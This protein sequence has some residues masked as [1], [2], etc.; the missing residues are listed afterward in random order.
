MPPPDVPRQRTHSN[1]SAHSAH[2][3]H[4]RASSHHR[5]AS[6][7]MGYDGGEAGRRMAEED[8]LIR[9]ELADTDA[10]CNAFWGTSS[11]G[12]DTV[13]ARMKHA[14][15]T[16][17]AVRALYKERADIEADYAKRLGKLSKA[18][19]DLGLHETG[20]TKIALETVRF[21]VERMSSTHADLG[22]MIKKDLDG[23]MADFIG[24]WAGA[25]RNSSAAI[26]KLW[27]QKQT[28]ESYVNKSRE[29]YEQD[30]IKIN[31]YTAQSSLVQGRDL[32]KVTAKLDKAQATVS[33]NEKDYQ[34][35]V[36]AL[37]DTTHK[38]NAE[39]KSY[40]DQCQD[41]EEERLDFIKA[42]LWNYANAVSAVCVA[43]DESCENVRV[44]LEN[45]EASRDIQAFIQAQGTGSAIPDPPEYINYARGQPP[46]ARPSYK[47]ANFQRNS[48]RPPPQ[49]PPPGPP[50]SQ[51]PPPPAV[52]VPPI[53]PQ[54]HGHAPSDA[55]TRKSSSGGS[56]SGSQAPRPPA[57]RTG[58]GLGDMSDIAAA[59]EQA[60]QEPANGQERGSSK[61]PSGAVALPGL[62]STQT[63]S[64]ASYA[65]PLAPSPA[66]E[67]A[68]HVQSV[69]PER[70]AI[71]E[72][73]MSARNFIART[74]SL[75]KRTANAPEGAVNQGSATPQGVPSRPP[76]GKADPE[77]DPLAKALQNLRNRPGGR[78]PAPP[79]PGPA[80][81]TKSPAPGE[82]FPAH[83][84]PPLRAA[85][86][87]PSPGPG[88]PP[89]A[90]SP[91][92]AF[93][94]A[95]ERA[96]SPAVVEEYG[97]SFPGERR[98]LSRQN[99]NVS[100][101]VPAKPQQH[102][103]Q[104]QRPQAGGYPGGIERA[105]SPGP[106][107]GQGFAGVGARG[108]SPS[109]A[110][111]AQSGVASRPSG[112]Q[113]QGFKAPQHPPVRSTTPL[114][115]SL[116]A[117][118]S[119]TH[120]QMAD[121][122]NRR[123]GS[124]GPGA[125]RPGVH[126]STAPASHYQQPS[127]SQQ[128]PPGQ[129]Y[130]PGPQA[131]QHLPPQQQQRPS[132][133][134]QQHPS[135]LY[136]QS[137]HHQ[138]QPSMASHYSGAQQQG[139]GGT[140]GAYAPQ[141][142]HHQQQMS[143]ASTAPALAAQPHGQP[144]YHAQQPSAHTPQPQDQYGSYGRAHGQANGYG[145]PAQSHSVHGI[146]QAHS[147]GPH[148]QQQQ[149]AAYG[150]PHQQ[151]HQQHPSSFA[152]TP[153]GGYQAPVQQAETPASAYMHQYRQSNMGPPGPQQGL[154]SQAPGGQHWGAP[155][156][157]GHADPRA[158]SPA[159]H[160]IQQ[161]QQQQAPINQRLPPPGEAPQNHAPTG[162]YSD[163]GKPILFYVSALYNYEATSEEEFSF[164][165]GDIIAIW[166]TSPDGWW[167]G[168]LLDENRRTGATLCPSNFLQLLA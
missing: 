157:G 88:G 156:G 140:P 151:H 47:H 90:R 4:S 62:H 101:H 121:E 51:G 9:R 52:S 2:S 160:H 109:P 1:N 148:V 26:E 22:N 28:Q 130:S 104:Q 89:R 82:V 159:P 36:R 92:A 5:R 45:C 24:N 21:E 3:A 64:P 79:S 137:A 162:Q 30:C 72:R 18:H 13:Q 65:A 115:I 123:A 7:S 10:F 54:A 161:Q 111:Q 61:P 75:S 107:G 128:F 145:G 49:L 102:A 149:Q 134:Q 168:D 78:S 38:W 15:K 46:P 106:G 34:N 68:P 167:R 94:N 136:Q 12:Y 97:Q 119:V 44:S 117:S 42:N 158:H 105:R 74:P 131:T 27:K 132:A 86:R 138:S 84:Q 135:H 95:P 63:N 80:P 120:D 16:M 60:P 33:G 11:A 124:V 112:Q 143:Y 32:D 91:S 116:D 71:P 93:M 37:K 8:E 76:P 81:P 39:W 19:A 142:G 146:Q 56:Q 69:A 129:S 141:A 163:S 14:S 108:R 35:F 73:R 150:A 96:P 100:Q 40:L 77:E 103:Q 53:T 25:R 144:G 133:Q 139:P 29:K 164:T 113:S 58:P 126:Q 43:D 122:Y 67:N 110:P 41:L 85:Q 98:A 6:G 153:G 20:Q 55:R 127:Q 166:E 17:D 57:S 147:P 23:A 118:G 48:T 154:S 50:P 114:G 83:Q 152:Q 66:A 125:Q 165:A 31:G 87:A 59:L 99:S 155:N 70:T